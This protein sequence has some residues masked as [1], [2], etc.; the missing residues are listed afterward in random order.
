MEA[1]NEELNDKNEFFANFYEMAS[2]IIKFE[3]L[4]ET[5]PAEVLAFYCLMRAHFC[6]LEFESK[7]YVISG[8]F[9]GGE[10]DFYY[11]NKKYIVVNHTMGS[12]ELDWEGDKDCVLVRTA[13]GLTPFYKIAGFEHYSSLL[14]E[15]WLALKVDIKNTKLTRLLRATNGAEKEGLEQAIQDA[16]EGKTTVAILKN[17]YGNNPSFAESLKVDDAGIINQV[18]EAI[19]FINGTAL[20]NMGLSSQTIMKKE[21][22]ITAEVENQYPSLKVNITDMFEHIKDGLER[23]NKKY[24]LNMKC[25]LNPLWYPAQ[26][27]DFAP[28]QEKENANEEI[29]TENVEELPAINQSET[30]EGSGAG[31][32]TAEE[33]IQPSSEETVD[34]DLQEDTET[35][36]ETNDEV[37]DEELEESEETEDVS[38]ETSEDE[39]EKSE[40]E[41]EAETEVETEE[42]ETEETEEA[43]IELN[44]ENLVASKV[45]IVIEQEEK[46][47]DSINSSEL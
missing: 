23:A 39:L 26:N 38:R 47:D 5:I 30:D 44:I 40:T 43:T 24:G 4:P 42:E 45:E 22:L 1:Y 29:G 6:F 11:R 27:I 9:G 31:T 18:M 2:N 12:K 17:P 16:D 25:Y 13:N 41:T 15:A 35:A 8:N 21:R 20:Q 7:P 19:T 28:G 14:E 46:T 34:E 10:L 37:E 36:S 32:G 3:D 33:E